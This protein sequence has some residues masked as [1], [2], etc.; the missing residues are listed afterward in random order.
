MSGEL[1]FYIRI[2]ENSQDGLLLLDR[3]DWRIKFINQRFLEMT[4]L[5]LQSV[6]DDQHTFLS[7]FKLFGGEGIEHT[8]SI[9][10]RKDEESKFKYTY[11]AQGKNDELLLLRLE[12]F[13]EKKLA[14][15]TGNVYKHLYYNLPDPVVSMDIRGNII[16]A[17]PAFT[18][19]LGWN[20]KSVKGADSLYT[21]KDAF[22]L[23]KRTLVES[24]TVLSQTASL[25]SKDGAE[26]KFFETIWPHFDE[27][28]DLSGYTAHFQDLSREELLKAQ[29]DASQ[30]NYN[31]LFE[32]FASSIVIVDELG[33][34]VNMNSA[35]ESM[36]GYSRV[37]VLGEDYDKYFSAGSDRPDILEIIN[38]TR[39]N[40]GR[41]VE[42]GIPRK[43]QNGGLLYTYV[44]YY[45]VDLSGEGMFAL[46]VLEKDLTTKIRLE[47]QLTDSLY[48]LKE[49]Q[50][51][52]IMGFAKLT[53]YRDHCTG[54]HLERVQDYT[55]ALAESLSEHSEYMGYITPE[56]IDDLSLSSVLHDIGKVG[57]KDS[58][59]LKA[60]KFSEEEFEMMKSH[61]K[62]GGDA[63]SVIA[64][65]VGHKSFLTIG[66]EVA[67]YHHEK[68]DGSGYPE[69]LKGTEIPLSAR[70]VG[71]ADV[72]DALRSERP[73]KKPFSHEEAVKLITEESGR[74]FDPDIVEAFI[75]CRDE[76][77]QIS[78]LKSDEE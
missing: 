41:Y 46:F 64:D 44:T 40:G 6:L 12:E 38:L 48:Q 1:D 15:W 5:E 2:F 19:L 31:R 32:Y 33:K 63:L 21:D 8:A 26:K 9:K 75:K 11:I 72:Y 54:G 53:E 3:K 57:I 16:T 22:N 67:S 10:S 65:D 43:R 77:A 66:K 23:R 58:V 17:N 47:K 13:Q 50:A 39:E 74:H 27:H 36:Y 37:E 70:I 71:L 14:P 30:T 28:Y 51:A 68:W 61:S 7:N 62:M 4:D 42:I 69:G 52:A 24:R 78:D 29:L 55:R 60:G 34:I 35:A 18:E 25:K 20:L 76:F 73:Y 45:I 59:L 56:Y 49:T